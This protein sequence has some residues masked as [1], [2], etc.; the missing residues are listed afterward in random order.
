MTEEDEKSTETP[1]TEASA[2]TATAEEEAAKIEGLETEVNETG[3]CK[4]EAKVRV[5]QEAIQAEIDKTIDELTP[6]ATIP[7]FR[8]GHAPRK[9]V[10]RHYQ[11]TVFE[12]VKRQM[13]GRSWEQLKGEHEL[14]P[15]GEPD[16]S[17]ENIEYDEEK[18]LS[19]SLALE[20]AP[21]FDITDYKGLKLTQPDT[22]VDEKDV[23]TAL[24]NLRRR[25][26]VLE[27]VEK[28][29]TKEDD[30]PVVDCDI[31]V[32]GEVIQS[33][34][35]QEI[36]L[37]VD[38]WLRGLDE[39]LWK[40]LLGKKAGES[41]VKTVTL[42]QTYQ[43]EPFRG[44]Q[45]EV[46]VT[47]KDIKR[48]RLPELNDDFAKGLLYE[49]LEELRK[50]V[51]QR[52]ETS[53]EREARTQLA[54]Q[55]EEKLLKMVDFEVPEDLLKQMTERSLNRQR[56]DLAYRGV[57]RDEIEKADEQMTVG[58]QAKSERDMRIYF[59]LQQIADKEGITVNDSE[60]ERRVQLLA[61]LQG[62]KPAA[63]RENLKRE[64]RLELL[65]S[66][67][68]DERTM[69]LLISEADIKGGKEKK[70]SPKKAKKSKTA[71]KEGSGES[72][73]KK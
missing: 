35:D 65:R 52:L 19:Y 42:P 25:N 59:I 11:S 30:V 23:D 40:D 64:G 72:E 6:N 13:I 56:M 14:R 60:L 37:G 10:E 16:L 18:G 26:A 48:P 5:P 31:R 54:G 29:Q 45:A 58:V 2:E 41:A 69:E 7:G 38:N 67:I 9:L 46:T 70:V 36:T 28:G 63:F 8:K 12:D 53:R 33:V 24:D 17:D 27:P 43:K 1:E 73:D 61:Q 34:S 49:N 32:D 15:M 50:D 68:C 4:V 21:R 44:S 57:P 3:P 66:E 22:A 39:E 20:V 51:R 71:S 55:V 47:I 62:A